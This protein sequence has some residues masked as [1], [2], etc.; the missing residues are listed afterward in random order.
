MTVRVV[1]FDVMDTVLRDPYREA[2]EA[3]TGL[4]PSAIF[5]RR[6]PEAYPA[7]ERGDLTEDEYWTTFTDAGVPVDRDAFHAARRAGYAWLDGMRD[8]LVDVRRRHTV[9]AAS[10]YPHWLDEVHEELL[11][12]VVDLVVG[13]HQLGA[14]KPEAAFYRGLARATRTEPGEIV[15]VDD[16]EVNIEGAVAVGLQAVRYESAAQVRCDLRAVGVRC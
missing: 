6:D 10:N 3:A 14:R 4:A 12:D 1:A 7:F 13:S 2:L 8:L 5:E 16:R 11:A 15:F 9:V